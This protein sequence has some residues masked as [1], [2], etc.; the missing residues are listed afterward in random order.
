MV[1]IDSTARPQIIKREHNQ[2][3]YDVVKTYCD[4]NN[5]RALI[6]TSFNVHE[7]PIIISPDLAIKGLLENRIDILVLS[8]YIVHRI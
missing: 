2:R 8:D 3:Y 5:E 7:Q 1:H 6:N 4:R